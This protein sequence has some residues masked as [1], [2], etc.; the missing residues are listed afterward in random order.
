MTYYIHGLTFWKKIV[1]IMADKLLFFKSVCR[2]I[3]EFSKSLV[4][5]IH[6]SKASIIFLKEEIDQWQK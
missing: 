5:Q 1:F 2:L 3:Y 4:F 6:I